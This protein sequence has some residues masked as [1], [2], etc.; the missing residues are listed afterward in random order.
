MEHS[1]T[2][3][4]GCFVN[5]L[6][7]CIVIAVLFLALFFSAYALYDSYYLSN[8]ANKY[9]PKNEEDIYAAMMALREKNPDVIGWIYIPDTNINYPI[10]QGEDNQEYLYLD[11]DRETTPGGSVFVDKGNASDFTDP[12]TVLY[13]HNMSGGLMFA[14]IAKMYDGAYFN[15]HTSGKLYTPDRILNFEISLSAKAESTNRLIYPVF[16][17]SETTVEQIMN[18][19]N[20]LAVHQRGESLIPGE[21]VLILSTCNVET[22]TG[23]YIAACRITGVT[24]ISDG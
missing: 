6:L 14:Q 4:I 3:K 10:L 24:P 21:Q 18:E 13:G 19:L 20:R 17:V 16:P 11:A 23:R 22:T 12:V 7:R 8:L 1:A 9:S 5:R 15:N 2:Y